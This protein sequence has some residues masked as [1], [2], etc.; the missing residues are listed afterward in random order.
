MADFVMPSLGADMTSGILLEWRVAVGDQVRHGEIIAEIETAKGHFEIEV[1]ASGRIEQLLRQPGP[2]Q[3]PVGTVL[4][5]IATASAEAKPAEPTERLRISPA[6]RRLAKEKNIPLSELAGSGPEGAIC[7]ADVEKAI[8]AALH[9]PEPPPPPAESSPPDFQAGMRQA[10]AAAKSRANREIPH[11]YL[12]SDID[13]SRALDWL[14]EQN[15]QR[16]IHQR[17]LPVVLAL[18]AVAVALAKVP[19]LNAHWVE[20]RLQQQEELNIGV[21]IALRGGGLLTPALPQVDRLDLDQLMAALS[22]LITRTRRGK[23]RGSELTKAGITVT[24]LGDLG[25]ERVYG[26]IYPPQVALVGLGRISERPWAEKGQLCVRPVLT[27][28]LA[29][30]HRASDGHQGGQFLDALGRALQQ[31]E[32]L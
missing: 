31:P 13:M 1:F 8:G 14:A 27:V 3:I 4:A 17:L 26:V 21:A 11:Y 6:A 2:E 9:A 20:D 32:Q 10:I 30:D 23:L 15:R 5:T 22:D 24:S 12:A 16:P 7:L 25:V 28:T 18:K 29:A 19:Q